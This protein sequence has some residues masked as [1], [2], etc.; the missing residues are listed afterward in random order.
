M[1]ITITDKNGNTND[2]EFRNK[3][4]LTSLMIQNNLDEGFG[5]CGGFLDCGTCHIVVESGG[6]TEK[7]ADEQDTIDAFVF[8]SYDN[9]RLGCQIKLDE[10]WDGAKVK[11]INSD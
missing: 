7:Q 8:E 11:V 1:K 2:Y 5:I 4:K 10:S 3:Q 9:S 6:S